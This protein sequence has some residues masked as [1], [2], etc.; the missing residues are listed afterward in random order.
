MLLIKAPTLCMVRWLAFSGFF[1]LEGYA[2]Y[3][4]CS[5][6]TAFRRV[7]LALARVHEF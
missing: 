4:D 6:L 3:L 5:S 7:V 1:N 2:R